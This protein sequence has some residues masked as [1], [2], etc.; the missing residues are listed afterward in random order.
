MTHENEILNGY[1]NMQLD[2][3]LINNICESHGISIEVVSLF[4]QQEKGISKD[5]QNP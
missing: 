4:E 5:E 3:K 1:Q 2:L